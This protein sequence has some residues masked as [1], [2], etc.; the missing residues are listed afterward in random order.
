M[1]K[2]PLCKHLPGAE[3]RF[4]SC[5]VGGS[6]CVA[7]CAE[8]DPLPPSPQ[9]TLSLLVIPASPPPAC[10][11]RSDGDGDASVG[12]RQKKGRAVMAG[13]PL[14]VA[15]AL[16]PL[17]SCSS[18]G[19]IMTLSSSS[20]RTRGLLPNLKSATCPG[21]S[22]FLLTPAPCERCSR[23]GP[24]KVWLKRPGERHPPCP[25]RGL[26]GR[27]QPGLSKEGPRPALGAAAGMTSSARL[28][29]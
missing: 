10:P 29:H 1:T 3:E 2:A 19:R 22:W 21:R 9:T 17:T 18:K 11:P 23:G 28:G 25:G 16:L 24:S 4:P 14:A 6:P 8:K 15:A 26:V 27:G 13:A 20:L 7:S 5:P 12:P